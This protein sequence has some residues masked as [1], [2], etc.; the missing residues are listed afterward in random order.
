MDREEPR[1][2][3][4]Q[5]LSLEVI[6]HRIGRHPSAV[7]YWLRK[8]ELTPVHRERHAAR[9]GLD[10]DVLASL[11][12]E[13]LSIRELAAELN[14]SY[15]TVHH[16]LRRYQLQTEQA[17]QRKLPPETRPKYVIRT[18]RNH[19]KTRFVLTNSGRHYRCGRCRSEAVVRRRRRMKLALIEEAG[20]ACQLC[21]FDPWPAALHFHHIDPATKSFEISQGGVTVSIDTLR[22]EAGKCAL[23]CANCHAGVEAGAIELRPSL[24]DSVVAHDPG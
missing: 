17:R 13:G 4:D 11:V 22:A 23:L 12:G 3:L 16:W 2:Y 20:G 6:S 1:G 5:G 15:T 21:G 10:R 24:L 8:F 19:G 18:C 14:I 9:G 7:S